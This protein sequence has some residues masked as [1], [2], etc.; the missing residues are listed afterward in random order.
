MAETFEYGLSANGFKRKRLPE[1]ISS[2]NARIADTLGMPIQTSANSVLGQIVGVFAYEIADE[3]EQLENAYNAM[4]PSTA[5]GTSLSNAAGLAGIHQIEAEYTSVV[6]TCFGVEGFEIPYLAQVTDGKYTYSCQDV[7]LPIEASRSNVVGVKPTSAEIVSGTVYSL[8]ID[9]ETQT[10]TATGTDTVNS[11]L[12]N[13]AAL[14]SFTDKTLVSNNGVL[15]ITMNEPTKTM[16]V[17]V[18]ST[19]TISVVA[20]PYNFLCDTAGAINPAIGTITQIVTTYA[21]WN[22]VENDAPAAVGRDAETDN[23][24]RSRWSRSMYNRASAMVEAVQAAVYDVDGVTFSLVYE[25]TGDTTDAAG[26]PPHSIEVVVDGG[27]DDAIA[28]AIW[29]TRAAGITTYGAQSG[30]TYDSQGVLRTEHF[31]RPTQIPVYLS[32]VVTENPEKALS[33]AALV[34]IKQ[35]V[36][37]KGNSI[38]IGTDVILQSFFYP[39]MTAASNAVGYIQLTASTDGVSYSADNIIISPREVATFSIENVTVEVAT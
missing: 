4:Y 23:A 26:R 32:V 38:G 3:W 27:N 34:L 28:K 6:L 39:I 7:Y 5:Q 1:I 30:S 15:M 16:S 9:S 35:A 10:Y 13:L 20:S 14:F 36:V 21:G 11:V 18:G 2:I 12:V 31:S 17:F 33:S 19:L 37:A 29:K 8:T 24:L 22:S 25:N